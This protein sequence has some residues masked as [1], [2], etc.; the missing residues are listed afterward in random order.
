MALLLVLL[1]FLYSFP[2]ASLQR[3]RMYRRILCLPERSWVAFGGLLRAVAA[4]RRR[5]RLLTTTPLDSE[6]KLP[7][8][9][10]T[11]TRLKV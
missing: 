2:E 4:C 7:L 3:R 11:Q 1:F 6:M 8:S 10:Y 5:V 9:M